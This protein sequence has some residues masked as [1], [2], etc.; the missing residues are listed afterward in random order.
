MLDMLAI[1]LVLF[2]VCVIMIRRRRQRGAFVLAY[3]LGLSLIHVPGIVN[4]MGEAPPFAGFPET[5]R[6]FEVTLAGLGAFLVGVRFAW[7]PARAQRLVAPVD[8]RTIAYHEIGL[9]LFASGVVAYFIVTPLASF[10]PSATSVLSSIG[11]LL[12]VGYWAL[13]F[14]AIVHRDGPRTL[15]V[16]A[17]IPLLPLSTL[18]T[19]GFI[20]YGV[21]WMIAI[22]SF[23]FVHVPRRQVLLLAISPLVCYLGLSLSIAYFAERTAIRD[24]V[25]HEQAGYSE[26]LDRIAGIIESF[27]FYTP[28]NAK[29]FVAID[30][31]MNQ[32]YL[33]GLGVIRHETGVTDLFYGATVP[34][35]SLVPRAIWPDK[36]EV[37][38]GGQVVS[39]FTGT[40]FAQGTSVGAGQ[41]LEFYANF[42]WIGVLA[43]FLIT[44][45]LLGRLDIG[46][47]NAFASGDVRAILTNGLPGLALLQPGGNLLEIFVAAVA[48]MVA[49]RLSF[50]ALVE[51]RLLPSLRPLRRKVPVG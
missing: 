1:W 41:P 30:E 21:Y 19:G 5:R 48:A 39:M 44:G 15:L 40:R 4:F 17:T 46:L 13:L 23:Y 42:G 29:H 47:S 45:A 27:D 51:L 11:S 25:W 26:R 34:W 31:R 3:F 37:G 2:V 24:A 28:D 18:A 36:P 16:L 49:A 8:P 20:G 9:V 43:G 22:V 50:F 38:G 35:W 12:I 7:R 6:G 32:N 14:D 10:I 33:V